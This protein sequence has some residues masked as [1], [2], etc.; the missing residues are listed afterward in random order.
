M[1]QLRADHADHSAW[2]I[3]DSKMR[4]VE[5]SQGFRDL[6]GYDMRCGDYIALVHPADREG[7]RKALAQSILGPE[8]TISHRLAPAAGESTR[9]VCRLQR[10]REDLLSA[11]M[12]VERAALAPILA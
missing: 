10:L 2:F 1:W 6:T 3:M 12:A 8:W 7:V 4:I 11:R 5:T 9:I